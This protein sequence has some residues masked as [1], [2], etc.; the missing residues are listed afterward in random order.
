M[1]LILLAILLGLDDGL[2]KP[3]EAPA[4]RPNILLVIADDL[5]TDMLRAYG[6]GQD[7]PKTPTLDALAKRS[8]LF[9]NAWSAPI[10]SPTRSCIQTGRFGFRTGIG[11]TVKN[12]LAFNGLQAS[13]VI[14]PEMLDAGTDGLYRPMPLASTTPS[15]AP[16]KARPE[17]DS[18]EG[19]AGSWLVGDRGDASKQRP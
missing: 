10:C 9:R 13:E 18:R 16:A 6:F 11:L 2:P 15:G 4:E 7:I 3:P 12:R 17:R 1:Y 8:V 19:S 5:G 14:L